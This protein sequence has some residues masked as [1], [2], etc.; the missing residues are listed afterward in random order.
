MLPAVDTERPRPLLIVRCSSTSSTD[1][2]DAARPLRLC[3]CDA[4]EVVRG[5]LALLGR[6]ASSPPDAFVSPSSVP[7]SSASPSVAACSNSR[8]TTL[9]ADTCSY[10]PWST[11]LPSSMTTTMSAAS[12]CSMWLVTNTRVDPLSAPLT[13]L[14]NRWWPTH[15]STAAVGS[16]RMYLRH[17]PG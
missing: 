5:R 8:N 10:V 13:H 17:S 12:A 11:I 6:R 3:A 14:V 9:E 4:S 2:A 1:A 15:A 16:S 7:C